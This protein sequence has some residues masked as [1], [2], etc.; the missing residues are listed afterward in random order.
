MQQIKALA[1]SQGAEDVDF[2]EDWY[3]VSP[4]TRDDRVMRMHDLPSFA[5]TGL[6]LGYESAPQQNQ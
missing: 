2:E 3:D 6:S 5:A 4:T 1:Y